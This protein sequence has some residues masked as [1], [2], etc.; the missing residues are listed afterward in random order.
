[1]I[2]ANIDRN[3]VLVIGAT[4]AG[5]LRRVLNA[6]GSYGHDHAGKDRSA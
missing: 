2:V 4:D 3:T 6:Y 5:K 1:M